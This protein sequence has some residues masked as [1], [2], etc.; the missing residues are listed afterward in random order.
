MSFAPRTSY[1][2]FG[3]TQWMAYAVARTG[4]AMPNC[5]TY[6]TARISEIVGHNQSLDGNTKVAGAG[7]L[8]ETHAPEFVQSNMPIPG[9]LAIYKG[10]YGNYGHVAVVEVVGVNMA[11][12]QSNY[13]GNLFDF[14]EVPKVPG[15]YYP[16]T[17]L[18]LCGFLIHNSL[19]NGTTISSSYS[20]K[21]LI[22]ENGTAVLTQA[23]N[24]RRDSPTG[25][26][27]ETLKKGTKLTYTQK[28][29]GN[30]HRYISWVEHQNDGRMYRYFVAISGS[31][32][33][34]A[35]MWATFEQPQTTP[36]YKLEDEHGWAKYKVDQVQIR[37]DSPTGKVVGT[38]NV[39]TLIEYTQKCATDAHRYIVYKKG[40]HNLFVA[41]SPT[42][43][44]STAWCDFYAT[45]PNENTKTL[46]KKIDQSNV[47]H[48]GVD[49]SEA[50]RE[51]DVDM[52]KYD[53]A[54]IRCNFGEKTSD[55]KYK[56]KKV[57]HW[58]SECN[59]HG[60]PFG[61]YCYDYAYDADG[62][63]LEAEYAV[64]LAE[65]YKP[66]LGIWFDMEDA[67]AWKKKRGLLTKEHCLEMC[68]TFCKYVKEKGW[69]TGVYSSTWWFDNWLTDLDDYDKWVA[70]WDS[71][72][73]NYNS[74]TSYR[75][76]IH[77]Y[78][79][80]DKATGIGLD[81]NAMYVDF[82]HYKSASKEV[83]EQQKADDG[84]SDAKELNGLL[85]TLISLLKK[86]L[87][88]FGKSGD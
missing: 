65:Q 54:I 75:G 73:G 16:G 2:N 37:Q 27:A 26:V 86:L 53:F 57:D 70:Q 71:N 48:W 45:S 13:G 63:K 10:G 82:D 33:Q 88:I 61:L 11:M 22:N 7:N 66:T 49:L 5:F 32:K 14:V 68:K 15:S 85:G 64:E 81:K 62:A 46:D 30:G 79:S 42:K 9:A 60:K 8:W 58:V 51:S 4:V 25:I 77:Q 50:N 44:R 72:D 29:V 41:C 28:W 83:T 84:Q 34:G 76:T 38:A 47:L 23:V 39:N 19:R 78:T 56:D 18:R 43:D 1:G 17:G 55:A 35:D 52:S 20:E 69:Y 12:S 40:G 31:E 87:S 24:K 6:A 36:N 3:N 67:D 80:I 59:K 74:D 21:Q